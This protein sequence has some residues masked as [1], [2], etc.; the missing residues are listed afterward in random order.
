ME[1]ST[2]PKYF[3]YEDILGLPQPY[4]FT[5]LRDGNPFH[6]N[7]RIKLLHMNSTLVVRNSSRADSGEYT[8][9]VVSASGQ[10]SLNLNLIVTCS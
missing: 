1:G 7:D 4:S 5:W 6:G 9:T 8:L 3:H 10:D 2:V